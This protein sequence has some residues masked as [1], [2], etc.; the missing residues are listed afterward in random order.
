M[1][2][3]TDPSTPPTEPEITSAIESLFGNPPQ[4]IKLRDYARF[5]IKG[6]GQAAEGHEADDL[7]SEAVTRT[8]EGKRVWN[9]GAVDIVGHLNGVMESVASHWAE[10]VSARR[11]PTYR[12]SQIARVNQDG[13]EINEF[14]QHPSDS[15]RPDRALEAEQEVRCLE[16]AFSDDEGVT[17]LLDAMKAEFTSGPEIQTVLGI[18]PT[19]YETRMK[20]L[21]RK[22]RALNEGRGGRHA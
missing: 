1:P 7:L 18:S 22:A 6:I 11:V 14:E 20:R 2:P 5:L 12:A 13:G 3:T 8:L 16:A 10:S 21:R 4:L 19:E 15:P 17:E 9:R